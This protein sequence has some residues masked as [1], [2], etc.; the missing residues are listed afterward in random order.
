MTLNA[1]GPGIVDLVERT[2]RED[3]G[4]DLS[5]EADITTR[6]TLDGE[7]PARAR[8]L[9]RSRGVLAGIDIACAV[10]T[11]VDPALT[12]RRRGVDGDT[13]DVDD[14]VL[15]IAGSA[16]A[17]LTGERTAL[18]FLQQLSG[19][20]TLTRAFVDTVIGTG[21]QITDT[22]KTV[23]GLRDPQKHAVRCG[24]GVS[25]RSGLHD[26]V[27]IKENHVTAA[28]GVSEAV[29]RARLGAQGAGRPDTRIM[30]EAEDLDQVRA[31]VAKGPQLAPD[32]ILL[33][34]MSP[35][36]MR[37][38]VEIVRATTPDVELEATGNIDLSTVRAAAESGVNLISV[39]ALTHSAPALDLSLLFIH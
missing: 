37:Q 16:A 3:L 24:G 31:L 17:I 11:R 12:L 9:A 19:V 38:C 6:W 26:A 34:N 20:A 23:P 39:G 13:V 27:L 36:L 10:F 29:R 21:A 25:H 15:E 14:S 5:P 4:G 32:R 22:R 2:L 8:I 33:D 1:V 30:C 35:E 18:N 28:G 7:T